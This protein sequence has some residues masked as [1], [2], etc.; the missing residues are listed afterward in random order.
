MS[1]TTWGGMLT[2]PSRP[3]RDQVPNRRGA[4][5]V[6][7]MW[8]GAVPA[9]N[10]NFPPIPELSRNLV[11]MGGTEIHEAQGNRIFIRVVVNG[12]DHFM[13]EPD[14]DD[15]RGQRRDQGA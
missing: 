6:Q 13:E 8:T 7:E 1:S 14:L 9:R 10:D 15:G 3:G 5:L 4:S 11:C 12:P 2:V